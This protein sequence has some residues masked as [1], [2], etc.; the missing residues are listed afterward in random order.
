MPKTK[1]DYFQTEDDEVTFTLIDENTVARLQKDGTITLPQ[2]TVDATKDMRWNM[3]Q[4]NSKLLQ[5][6]MNGDP[7]PKIAQSFTEVIGN[8]EVST[9]RAA[10]TMC[11]NAENSGRQD[12][13][14]NLAAQGVVQ[15]KVW[16]ATPDDRTREAHL[17][18]DGQEVD[19]DEPFE[20]INTDGSIC[21][22]MFPAD[23]DGDDEQVWNCRCSMRTHIVG[24]RKAD[25]S[26]SKVDYGRDKTTHA[27]Q[28]AEEKERREQD[29]QAKAAKEEAKAEKA[30]EKEVAKM[31]EISEKKEIQS[32]EFTEDEIDTLEWYVSGDGMYINNALRGIS[33][34]KLT[35]DEMKD[36]KTL[37]AAIAKNVITENELYRSVDASAVFGKMSETQYE[38]LRNALIYGAE[39]N[40]QKQILE[41]AKS[42]VGKDIK[43]KGFLSTTTDKDIA[44]NFGDFTGSDKPITMV[45]EMADDI[46]GANLDFLDVAGEE[47]KER[48]LERNLTYTV[49]RFGIENVYEDGEIIGKEIVVYAKLKK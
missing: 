19:V 31:A 26:V 23:P 38:E 44:L 6:I 40:A 43:D 5:G 37:D 25:G 9:T 28:M 36:V 35:P 46:H 7:I 10:R 2:K 11:T 34:V 41:N 39:T 24:F 27:D 30:A 17:D 12:S 22:M 45:F 13:Y 42:A 49:E 33:D 15:K 3:K 1:F 14:D 21:L 8:N 47:Q 29:A 20:L 4:L 16:I 32:A 18:A 48:L